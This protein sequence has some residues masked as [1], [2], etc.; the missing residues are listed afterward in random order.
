MG[1]RVGDQTTGRRRKCPSLLSPR[2]P[3]IHPLRQEAEWG[4]A[5]EEDGKESEA[6]KCKPGSTF[7]LCC[8]RADF[9]GHGERSGR[10]TGHPWKLFWCDNRTVC[11]HTA[12]DPCDERAPEAA[13]CVQ[14]AHRA[15]VRAHLVLFVLVR[16]ATE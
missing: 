15:L 4:A 10:R 9:D 12:L 2:H 11:Y 1:E 16:L 14:A 6:V 7:S 13:E 8:V 5:E 3:Y